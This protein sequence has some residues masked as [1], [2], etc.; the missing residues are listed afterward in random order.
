MNT[1]WF[2][3]ILTLAPADAA[4]PNVRVWGRTL[5]CVLLA[6]VVL[7]GACAKHHDS[8]DKDAV[9][10]NGGTSDGASGGSAAT[11]GSAGESG[12]VTGGRPGTG[13]QIGT[14]DG[15]GAGG[16]ATGGGGTSSG[17]SR[18]G[19]AG[20]RTSGGTSSGAAGGAA[21]GGRSGTGGTGGRTNTPGATVLEVTD[22]VVASDIQHFGINL[23]DDNY[24]DSVLNK[25]RIK[26]GGFE[27]VMYRHIARG[28]GGD[29]ESLYDWNDYSFTP[30][31]T[32]DDLSARTWLDVATGATAWILA[33]DRAWQPDVVDR[34]EHALMPGREDEGDRLRFVL[35]DSGPRVGSANGRTLDEVGLLLEKVE[36]WGFIGQ[37][38][39]PLWTFASDGASITTAGNDLPPATRGSAV[40]VLSAPGAETAK[41]MYPLVPTNLAEA[42]GTWRINFW[43]KGDGELTVGYGPWGDP[44]GPEPVA[45]TSDW[46]Y[47]E[48][49]PIVVS[50]YTDDSLNLHLSVTDGTVLLD[51][52]A[53][54]REGDT[55]PTAFSDDLVN[56]LHEL[57][58]GS[59]RHLQVGG[60]S[61]ENHLRP[62]HERM[63][64]EFQRTVPPDP[65]VG[66]PPHPYTNGGAQMHPYGLHEFLGLCEEVETQPWICVSGTTFPEEL[67][68]LMEYL[69][70]PTSS[71]YGKLRAD[72]GHAQP[73]TGV[74]DRIHIEIGN[75]A[76]NWGQAYAYGGWN[77][78]EYWTRLFA[79]AKTKLGGYG[80]TG[81]VRFHIGAQNYN[82][83]LGQ[84]LVQN[85][86]AAADGYAIA[87]YVIHEMNDTQAGLDDEELF[88]WAFGWVWYLDTGGPMQSNADM[89][90]SSVNPNLEISVYEVN[91]HI[92]GGSAPTEPRNRIVTSLGGALNVINHMLLMLERHDVRV[93]NFFSLFQRE[94]DGVGLW[95][96]VL[97]ARAGQERYRPSFQAL[98]LANRVLD[99]DL[100]EVDRS[101]EDPTW[102]TTFDYEDESVTVDVPYVHAYAT[103]DGATRGL[104]LLNLH[105]TEALPVRLELSAAPTS[106][107]TR[108]TLAGP[109]IA[110]NNEPE[111]EPE[112]TVTT[113]TA[114][115]FADGWFTDLPAHSMTVL[116]WEQPT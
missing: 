105:P 69:A 15:A 83:W 115:D 21:T 32:D 58:P 70:G 24:W 17:G 96:S 40:A 36:P 89:I 9:A 59:L 109:S 92:T 49:L 13:G 35:A 6:T 1:P 54:Y 37:H 111:H 19:F 42:N 31:A 44:Q 88:S 56:L 11:G 25:N 46:Q 23:G 91:H 5:W 67:Q 94:Y 73:W 86:G 57:R 48:D 53:A 50:S 45:L 102:Q 101:G 61:I 103:A 14:S 85:H 64:F 112:V 106:A 81:R 39:A 78:P 76:W 90:Q 34:I 22:R 66:W 74:F 114:D 68:D 107:A 65:S 110:A 75:E 52:V 38:G 33:G 63:A 20:E 41:L 97:S 18:W 100:V 108:W 10:G 79:D 51:D 28:P 99:G 113:E 116:R 87:P 62:D 93:Q 30:S 4:G 98:A 95:G 77:G 80:A 3:R 71:P 16:Q 12:D 47:F 2:A 60:S 26:N 29:A 84:S 7:A 43:A 55:N 8:T 72:R 82:T 104:I 27:G